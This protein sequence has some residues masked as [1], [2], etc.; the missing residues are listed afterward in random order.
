MILVTGGCGYIGSHIVK[1]LSESGEKVVVYDNLSQSKPTSLL[2]GEELIIGDIVD[3]PALKAA[4][5]KH[6]ITEVIHC[7]ALVNAAES[8]EKAPEYHAVN[9]L[10]SQ[11]V[12][13][14]G[15]TAGVKHFLYASSA[16]VYGI[17]VSQIAIPETAATH[18]SN[19]YGDSKLAGEKS[20]QEMVIPPNNYL[21]FRFFNV[22][23][24]D[25]SGE[26]KQN[27]D[28]LAI[29]Q[30]LLA[31]ASGRIDQ[32]TINGN[33]YDTPDGT[34][35]RDFIHVDDLVQA[36]LLG[37]A[38]LRGG[39]SSEVI[40]LGSGSAHTLSEV[41]K[42]VEAVTGKQLRITYGPRAPGDI[43]FSL[44]D[45]T[46]A[47]KVLQWSPQKSLHDLITDAWKAYAKNS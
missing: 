5:A 27:S 36:F 16:A 1:K 46:K 9:A 22:G 42:E 25:I 17:P 37:L 3:L 2:S 10:G 43:S 31:A 45:T 13:S 29:I 7:A 11:N 8:V 35:V 23:G 33:D 44:A 14:A 41:I 40:N 26:L 15:L 12:W 6:A 47:K 4:F 28:S 19:P 30:R 20:L 18:P 21:S 34:V 24:A 39:G 32:I 38:Y